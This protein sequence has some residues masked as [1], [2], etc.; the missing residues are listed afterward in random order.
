ME[1]QLYLNICSIP[2][3]RIYQ[4]FDVTIEIMM[5]SDDVLHRKAEMRAR[6]K[7]EFYTHFTIFILV[8]L[9][10]WGIWFVTD[11]SS[12]PWPVFV[13]FGW[14]IGITAHFV[15]SILSLGMAEKMIE[16]EYEKLKRKEGRP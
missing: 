7:M 6:E 2:G 13:T 15:N 9:L 16:K 10:L 4:I 8:N 11:S 12:F 5:T 3:G 14:G 1:S